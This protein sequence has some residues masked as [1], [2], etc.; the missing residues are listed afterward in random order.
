M[1]GD[2]LISFMSCFVNDTAEPEE[3]AR[4]GKFIAALVA[5]LCAAEHAGGSGVGHAGRVDRTAGD[6]VSSVIHMSTRQAD[7]ATPGSRRQRQGS[8]VYYLLL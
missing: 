4:M 6:L 5:L 7:N 8:V 3:E 2:V 1:D